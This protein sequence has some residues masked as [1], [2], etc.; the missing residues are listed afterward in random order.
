MR[1]SVICVRILSLYSFKASMT[2]YNETHRSAGTCGLEASSEKI[3]QGCILCPKKVVHHT[4]G[5]VNS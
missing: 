3:R 2:Q 5:V 1:G 4:H